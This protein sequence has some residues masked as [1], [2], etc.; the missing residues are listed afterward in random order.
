MSPEVLTALNAAHKIHYIEAYTGR[1][2]CY[3]QGI[4]GMDVDRIAEVRFR[5]NEM[6]AIYYETDRALMMVK[7]NSPLLPCNQKG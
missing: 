5:V 6:P 2:I 7:E 4:D 1:H 3:R